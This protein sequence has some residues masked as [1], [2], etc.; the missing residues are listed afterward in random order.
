[1]GGALRALAFELRSAGPGLALLSAL[2]LGGVLA[3]ALLDGN[4]LDLGV[5]CFEV[6]SPLFL[7]VILGEWGAVK[8]D[9]CRDIV[10][11]QGR[12]LLAWVLAKFVLVSAAVCVFVVAG[13]A[14]ACALGDA[15]FLAE[16]LVL[17]APPAFLFATA[18][19]LFNCLLGQEHAATLACCVLWVAALV[20]AGLSQ[21]PV[22]E[23][24]YPFPG[25]AGGIPEGQLANRAALVGL[26][27]LGW[28][29]VFAVCKSRRCVLDD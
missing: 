2:Y 22:L 11:A 18:C 12:S 10:A 13:M 19:M 24:L 25:L 6:A 20:S 23:L 9:G 17:F 8:T 14:L 28:A 21:A 3:A 1:M 15:P 26:S 27:V 29:G 5:V 16:L 7:A 4:L